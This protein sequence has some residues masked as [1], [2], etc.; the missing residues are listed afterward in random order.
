M[1]NIVEDIS[2][3]LEDMSNSTDLDS[4]VGL[5]SP[6]EEMKSLMCLESHDVRIVGIWGMGGV[7][8]TTI[9]SVVF[10]QIYVKV[11]VGRCRPKKETKE[12]EEK[13]ERKKKKWVP[14]CKGQK[15]K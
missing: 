12:K 11:M 2:K 8:E 10:H 14:G 3:K 9:A 15:K 4:F 5:N 13:E 6:I 1:E 7:G